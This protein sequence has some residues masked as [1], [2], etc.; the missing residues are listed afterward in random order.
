M[1]HKNKPIS[2]TWRWG[3]YLVIGVLFMAGVVFFSSWQALRATEAR[4]C[5]TLDFVKSQSTSF[6]KYNDTVVAKALRRAAVSVH[7]LAQAPALDLS[8]P[9][10]L[11]RQAELLWLTGIS[12]LSPDGTLLCESTTNGIGYAQFGE[13]LK[14]DAV[15]DVFAYPQKTYLKRVLLEDGSAVDVAA[16]RA[17]SKEVILLAYRYKA[18]IQV[19][20]YITAVDGTDVKSMSSVDAIQTRLRGESGTTVNVTWLDSE[21]AEHTADLTHSGYSST[22]VDYQMVQG[23]VG[24]IRIRQFDST[25][26]SELDYAIRSLSANG[27]GSLVFDLRDNGGG[28]LDDAIQCIDLIAPEGTLAFAEDK[29][30]TR[31]LLGT[32]TSESQIDLPVVCL[33][34][35]S[36]ASAAELFASSLRTLNGARLV[37]TTTQGKGTIQ[38]SPQR[39]SDGS[40]VVVTV[41][42]L[43]CGDGSCFDGTGLTVDVERPL[44]ADEQTASYD[45]TVENDPQ[46][47]RAVSTAQQMSGTTTVSGV[48]EAASSEAADSAAAESTASSSQE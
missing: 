33:V 20:N 37:G 23:N 1:A 38:S 19:G 26:P 11:N 40:A 21:A 10:C 31:T 13:Q 6:E 18:G 39:L 9:Q 44:T 47:Q 14:N 2:D 5:Q 28:L 27:A 48:N 34:N 12:V 42:K 30:G 36:T 35:G 4:F 45:Y 16:H 25:T 8:D 43:V 32:S 15:L 29:N 7:Q 17:E 22:T 41:A 24:Y 46:I 3:L